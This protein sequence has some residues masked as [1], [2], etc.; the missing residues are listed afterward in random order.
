MKGKIAKEI[1]NL[2][3]ELQILKSNAGY[4]IGTASEELGPVS[5]E[6]VEYYKKFSDAEKAFSLNEWTQKQEP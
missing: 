2:D 1:L 3:L 4:Y 5:R 6:S